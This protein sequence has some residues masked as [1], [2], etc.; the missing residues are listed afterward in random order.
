MCV[1]GFS[2]QHF[3]L[4][5]GSEDEKLATPHCFRLLWQVWLPTKTNA[6]LDVISSF[7]FTTPAVSLSTQG[8]EQGLSLPLEPPV[9]GTCPLLENLLSLSTF[10]LLAEHPKG[11]RAETSKNLLSF[12]F[13]QAKVFI[14]LSLLPTLPNPSLQHYFFLK[15]KLYKG[16]RR[17]EKS[18]KG[19]YLQAASVLKPFQG[20]QKA[21]L[22]AWKV[23]ATWVYPVDC[24]NRLCWI[25]SVCPS[26]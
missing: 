1:A 3:S 14:L 25:V 18:Q 10:L 2:V 24:P 21:G 20:A 15:L 9:F 26:R 17:G 8:A 6:E 19:G 23:L 4:Y 12:P 13:H 11:Q 7:Q 5:F 16:G 22:F